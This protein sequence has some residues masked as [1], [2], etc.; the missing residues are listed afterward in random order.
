MLRV[1]TILISGP[2]CILLAI[3]GFTWSGYELNL[4]ANA[5]IVGPA[6]GVMNCLTVLAVISLLKEI[7][8]D[9]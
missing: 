1:L 2:V 3:A 7:H 9:R 5:M 4:S 6:I 8:Y